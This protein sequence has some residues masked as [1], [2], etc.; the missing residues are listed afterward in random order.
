LP[1]GL[2]M[3]G[4]PFDEPMLLRIGDSY[5]RDTNWWREGPA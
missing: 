5:E 2:Q 4:K 3:T 1:I